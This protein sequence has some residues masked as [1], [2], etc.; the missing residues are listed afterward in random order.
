MLRFVQ[1]A[2]PIAVAFRAFR[3]IPEA[4]YGKAGHPGREREE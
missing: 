2:I 4:G 3:L 1:G